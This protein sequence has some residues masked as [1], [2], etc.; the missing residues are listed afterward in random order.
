LTRFQLLVVSVWHTACIGMGSWRQQ[1]LST[2]PVQI[3]P[4]NNTLHACTCVDGFD[5]DKIWCQE[6]LASYK[7][8]TL[9]L[10]K[11]ANTLELQAE[12]VWTGQTDNTWTW[13][14]YCRKI[15][16]DNIW[17]QEL[18][19][20]LANYVFH[21]HSKLTTNFNFKQ[22]QCM[23]NYS[24]TCILQLTDFDFNKKTQQ[25]KT[26][27]KQNQNTDWQYRTPTTTCTLTWTSQT[28]LQTGPGQIW[29]PMV[30][31]WEQLSHQPTKL[32]KLMKSSEKNDKGMINQ[33]ATTMVN[34]T[35]YHNKRDARDLASV[36]KD[37]LDNK[38]LDRL[39]RL[40]LTH[41]LDY[42]VQLTTVSN[43]RHCTPSAKHYTT[44]KL[45]KAYINASYP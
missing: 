13:C 31:D 17:C 38:L 5:T 35:N 25:N 24:C 14:S 11:P 28:W 7:W 8:L 29:L 45:Y 15:E 12:P 33:C 4:A 23:N 36:L 37:R 10:H 39:K 9:D 21:E 22:N 34:M 42:T 18:N 44:Q 30:W 6:L 2:E 41:N 40:P 1:T 3:W 27:F 20:H 26:S 32:D 19:L 43:L 16:T